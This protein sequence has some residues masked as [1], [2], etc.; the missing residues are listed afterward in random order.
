[1]A[2]HG[3]YEAWSKSPT[4]RA[5]SQ[6]WLSVSRVQGETSDGDSEELTI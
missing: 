3:T 6:C 1:M 5:V 4:H 2:M